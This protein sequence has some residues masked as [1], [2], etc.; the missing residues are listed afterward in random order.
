MKFASCTRFS[1]WI[2]TKDAKFWRHLVKQS[3][4]CQNFAFKANFVIQI[5]N[6][7]PVLDNLNGFWQTMACLK[8]DKSRRVGKNPIYTYKGWYLV[9]KLKYFDI[10]GFNAIFAIFSPNKSISRARI[11]RFYKNFTKIYKEWR[12]FSIIQ[13]P[14]TFLRLSLLPDSKNQLLVAK[15]YWN[16]QQICQKRREMS[17]DSPLC[18]Y[19]GFLAVFRAAVSHF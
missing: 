5:R 7:R 1:A 16:F 6:L 3:K 9:K 14:Q 10:F 2:W 19:F 4:F 17:R 15:T 13:R 18:G 11:V 12:E 8:A